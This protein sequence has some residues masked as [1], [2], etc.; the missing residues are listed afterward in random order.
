MDQAMAIHPPA[1]LVQYLAEGR[2]VLF[3]GA[4]L[5]ASAKLPGWGEL[6]RGLIDVVRD[7][8]PMRSD[9]E[10]LQRLLEASRFLQV[11][12]YCKDRLGKARYYEYLE[13]RLQPPSAATSEVHR[14]ISRLP[15]RA[16]VTTNYDSLL[17]DS[18][19]FETRLKPKAPTH[20]D[21]EV[22]GTLLFDRTFFVLK[23]HGDIHRPDTMILTAR[24]YRDIIH[25]N[26]AFGAM[27]T[28]LL[29][30]NAILFLGYSL[31]DPDLNLL[32][33]G[34]LA[35][36]SEQVPPRYALMTDVGEVQRT[37]LK[38]AAGIDVQSF[39][40]GQYETVPEYL[41]AL[42]ERL[43]RR[44]EQGPAALPEDSSGR[45]ATGTGNVEDSSLPSSTTGTLSFSMQG[46]P[47]LVELS[48][49]LRGR[50]LES[51]FT[52]PGRGIEAQGL[53]QFLD[54]AAMQSLLSDLAK[55]HD[56]W[57]EDVA[58]RAGRALANCLPPEVRGTLDRGFDETALILRL[59]TEIET[60]PWEW[61]EIGD[62]YLCFRIPMAR[63]PIGVADAARGYPQVRTPLRVLLVGDP[64]SN[65]PGS[66]REVRRIAAVYSR[67]PST[68]CVTL[69][70][71]EAT[72]QAVV[73]HLAGG[74]YDIF[75]FAGHAW[76]DRREAYLMLRDQA[77]IRANELRSFLG[78]RPPAILVLNS[79]FTA[80]VPLGVHDADLDP[81]TRGLIPQGFAPGP[82]PGGQRGFTAMASAVGVG[83]MVGCFG[84]PGDDMGADIGLK[85][86][87]ELIAG[88][89]I[90][91][92]LHRAR[93]SAS[94]KEGKDCTALVYTLSGYTDLA[95]PATGAS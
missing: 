3:A 16:I 76:Y 51:R 25:R 77:V 26:P 91:F 69:I 82:D 73:T 20:A 9:V 78:L 60:I 72:F 13:K 14:L 86:H 40:K 15:F 75:H 30:T 62:Q 4:G 39:P 18:Y 19:F 22:L 94:P 24:D 31:G 2:C 89:P 80:F 85:L 42:A 33:D 21:R 44:N 54:R 71:P 66:E 49:R 28:A 64:L 17:E 11:A 63:A 37:V 29:M 92:A 34:Q 88:H 7:N 83:A 56:L 38:Q 90:A 12:D 81:V 55:S 1:S 35:A 36:F 67:R 53:G 57:D 8:D 43:E 48:L 23:A 32:L 84:S 59:S 27:F 46:G 74:S 6:L 52:D 95:L 10:E 70:G 87:E 58:R 68:E 5:S 79:H 65:L 61:T 93:I 47:R 50:E 41:A 45:G